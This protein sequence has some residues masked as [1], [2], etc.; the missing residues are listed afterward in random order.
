M[1]LTVGRIPYLSCEPFYFAME[2]RGIPGYDVVPS[3]LIGA[4]ARGEIDAGPLPLTDCFHLDEQFRFL[5]GFCMA[6]VR[7][8]GS[9]VLHSKPPIQELTGARIGVPGEAAT[10]FRLLQVV[11]ALK[12]QVH[13]AAYVTLA[14]SYDAFF[15]MGNEGLRQRHGVRD[16]PHAYDLGEEW[17]QWTGLPFVFARWIVRKAIDP[18]EAAILEDTLYAGLQ[19]WADGLFHFS[20]SRDDLLMHPRDML[21]YTQ[22][23][24][25]FL[26]VPEQRAIDLFRRHLEQL[27]IQ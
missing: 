22:G 4:A 10:S 27:K 25:Y 9:V 19:D 15:L 21:E 24:R 11:L 12:Y 3:A 7:K 8:A 17:Y 6:T 26:G 5:S 14:D 2:R 18:T 20:D 23:I 1:A 13:P 16:F